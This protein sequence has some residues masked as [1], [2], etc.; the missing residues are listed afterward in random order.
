MENKFRYIIS[1]LILSFALAVP[2]MA[3][4]GDAGDDTIHQDKKASYDYETHIGEITLTSFVPG[5]MKVVQKAKPLE[6]VMVLDNSSSMDWDR[7]GGNG[8][9]KRWETLISAMQPF[10]TQIKD[11]AEKNN[12]DHK[13]SIIVFGGNN[14]PYK[15]YTTSGDA[16]YLKEVAFGTRRSSTEL[17]KNTSVIK[18]F[19]SV[20]TYY[21]DLYDTIGKFNPVG[22]NTATSK[23]FELAKLVFGTSTAKKEDVSRVIV[24]FSDGVPSVSGDA[25]WY[26]QFSSSGSKPGNVL[27][28][29]RALD[30]CNALKA[31]GVT[32]YSVYYNHK[33]G[34]PVKFMEAMSSN[35][36]TAKAKCKNDG[37]ATTGSTGATDKEWDMGTSYKPADF[38]YFIDASQSTDDLINAF[39]AIAGK[40][41]VDVNEKYDVNTTM[42]DFV[43]NNYFQYPDNADKGDIKVYTQN[44]TSYSKGTG[45]AP[46]L[47]EFNSE[48]V[49]ITSGVNVVLTRA[50]KSDPTSK[51]LVE[52]YGFNYSENWCGMDITSGTPVI[53][54]K[55]LVI[56]FPFI[57]KG[58]EKVS[59]ALQTN[60]KESGIYPVQKNDDGTPKVD[61]KGKPIP[62]EDTDSKFDPPVIYFNTLTITRKNLEPGETAIYEVTRD[63]SFIC[64]IALG[65]EAGKET[66]GVSKTIYG[67]P[68]DAGVKFKVSET[69]WNWAYHE[70]GSTLPSDEKTVEISDGQP[71]PLEY[72]FSGAHLDKTGDHPAER[73][74]HGE[75][76]VVNKMKAP[77]V[78]V[79]L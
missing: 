49:D 22:S 17:C 29:N 35:Y 75:S 52:V 25:E 7:G 41:E 61:E 54:G 59:G 51:D 10:L 50:V 65:G 58:G 55:Q 39:K 45:G 2:A 42:K 32:V 27:E 21:D 43:N 78:P 79:S 73:H 15:N 36:L 70:D 68:G 4:T 31:D 37:T 62:E 24:F 77:A 66:E 46:D 3:Q 16:N 14:Y 9:P 19:Y 48:L 63:G 28:A 23:G 11:N 60:T 6:L 74:N 53:H 8:N 18:R 13:V 76:F 30:V 57:F 71:V 12:V 56:K 69:N 34:A 64:R 33:T 26:T 44:C 47:Y 38:S 67:L 72:E 5:E 40:I 1:L 20:R